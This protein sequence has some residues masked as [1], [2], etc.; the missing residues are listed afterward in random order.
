MNYILDTHTLLWFLQGE[1]KLS[2]TVRQ[3]ILDNTLKKFVSI[4][5]LWEIAIK[6]RI[7]KLPLKEGIADIFSEI[8]ANGFGIIGIDC[9]SV[10]IYNTLPLIH[11]DPFDAMIIATSVLE[12]MTIITADE[13][14][15]KYD[16]S[17]IW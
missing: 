17:W 14:I 3:I 12:Q 5:S 13:N 16:V 9:E 8:K 1:E 2:E 10:E 15:Q 7:G 6:N 4:A 11:R